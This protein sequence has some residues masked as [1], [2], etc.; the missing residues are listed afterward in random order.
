M[1]AKFTFT[2]SIICL[3][4]SSTFAQEKQKEVL[5]IG[6]M[7][8]VPSIVKNSYRPLLKIAKKYKPEAI[9]VETAMPNDSLSWAYL[10]DGYSKF[11]QKFYALSDSLRS[12]NYVFDENKLNDLLAKD[13]EEMNDE[14]FKEIILAFVYLRDEP[15][16]AYYKYVQRYGPTGSKKPVRNEDG[17]LTAKLALYLNHKKVF[18]TDDQQTNAEF[19]EYSPLCY[20]AMYGTSFA[21]NHNKS[22]KKQVRKATIA[23]LFGRFGKHTNTIKNLEMLDKNSG[24]R[25]FDSS[26][27][28]C[29]FAVQYWDERNERIVK[30]MATQIQNASHQKSVLIIGASHIIGVKKELETKYPEIKVVMLEE[31]K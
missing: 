24:L 10:K 29:A 6:T 3:F 17:D 22:V 28:A 15:N 1:F 31:V 19:H 4:L 30:N 23:A 25:N 12:S 13:F 21:K 2:F 18:A 8:T 26:D 27:E 7:H 14:N 9:Y 11:L 16:Y 5:L 20:K